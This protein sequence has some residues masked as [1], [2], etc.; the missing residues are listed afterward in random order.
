MRQ[1]HVQP[2]TATFSLAA[3]HSTIAHTLSSLGASRSSSASTNFFR[4]TILLLITRRKLFSKAS[5]F[6]T[7]AGQKHCPLMFTTGTHL[8]MHCILS[9]THASCHIAIRHAAALVQTC[10]H[11]HKCMGSAEPMPTCRHGRGC[12]RR[13]RVGSCIPFPKLCCCAQE[14]YAGPLRAACASLNRRRQ[15]EQG[16]GAYAVVH[17]HAITGTCR[18]AKHRQQVE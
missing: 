15:H 13:R 8:T 14:A 6:T 9:Q 5:L 18:Q 2:G 10:M 1:R 7:S 16:A 12:A 3:K 4:S 11:A 17:L